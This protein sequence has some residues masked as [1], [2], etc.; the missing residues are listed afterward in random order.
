MNHD[1]RI[2]DDAADN[3]TIELDRLNL[4]T[5]HT[6]DIA[7]KT[8]SVENQIESQLKAGKLR[9][10]LTEITGKWPGDET[11]DELLQ[12]LDSMRHEE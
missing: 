4:L 2:P 8:W 11:L 5:E 9:N 12:S 1:S 6:M 10:P 7:T 3:G